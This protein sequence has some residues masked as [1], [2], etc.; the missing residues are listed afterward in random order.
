M[1]EAP[2]GAVSTSKDGR[3]EL[4][5]ERDL[6]YAQDVVWRAVSAPAMIGHWLSE[7]EV[8][9]WPGGC[10]RLSGQCNVEGAV[11]EVAPP[12]V[13]RWTW[14]HPDHPSSEVRIG[15]RRLDEGACRVTLVQTDLPTRHLLDVAAGWHTHLDALAKAVAGERTAFDAE[16]AAMHYRRYAAAFRA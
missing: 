2:L 11:V 13:L 15:I 6:P 10:F 16:R 5:F 12:S 7:A 3:H 1:E 14:P 4:R 9:L 8:E